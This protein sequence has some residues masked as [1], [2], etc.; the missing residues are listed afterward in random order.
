MCAVCTH[1]R[2]STARTAALRLQGEQSGPRGPGLSSCV[3]LRLLHGAASEVV[4]THRSMFT[5]VGGMQRHIDCAVSLVEELWMWKESDHRYWYYEFLKKHCI[6]KQLCYKVA[7][8]YRHI[9]SRLSAY[10]CTQ[11]HACIW[12]GGGRLQCFLAL[13][14]EV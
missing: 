7:L 10:A 8:L 4:S 12:R 3:C 6:C 11:P 5:V 13:G 2:A 14:F 9:L 1:M